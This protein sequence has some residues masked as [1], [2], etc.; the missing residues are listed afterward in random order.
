[1][2]TAV[3]CMNR[4]NYVIMAP[5]EVEGRTVH[6]RAHLE[7]CAKLDVIQ[8]KAGRYFLHEHPAEASSWQEGCIQQVL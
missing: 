5:D 3:S 8:W 2:C 1:M 7:F 4:T 6:G